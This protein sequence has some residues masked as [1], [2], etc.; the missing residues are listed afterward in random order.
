MKQRKKIHDFFLLMPLLLVLLSG[1]GNDR[2]LEIY[3]E[4]MTNFT[5]SIKKITAQM[6][7][8]NPESEDAELEMMGCLNAMNTQFQMLA[9]MDVPKEFASVE[10]LADEASA[11]MSEAVTLYSEIF[12]ANEYQ[13]ENVLAAQ[14]N[15]DRAMKRISYI[16]ML[17]Q[18]ELPEGDNITVT[19]EEALDFEPV[20]DVE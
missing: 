16:S 2:E 8:I 20:T 7:E 14:E 5:T 11:Y 9:Q 12:S 18:G 10:S 19:K 4:N 3:N 6:D 15:Y 13:E 17:L 1:C